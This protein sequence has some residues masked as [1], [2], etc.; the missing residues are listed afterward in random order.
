MQ[1]CKKYLPT[2]CLFGVISTS[3]LSLSFCLTHADVS[4]VEH[5][6]KGGHFIDTHGWNL[7]DPGDFVHNRDRGETQLSLT[8]IQ[9]WHNSC[10]F[11]LR[12][13]LFEDL[14]DAFLVFWRELERNAGVVLGRVTMLKKKLTVC[15]VDD[16]W[17]GVC[18]L[19]TNSA[20]D[21]TAEE[22]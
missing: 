12:R 7:K 18:K 22:A 19:T 8:E 6:V 17:M 4:P 1:S 20:S 14:L 21:R 10:L 11:V 9:K 15:C 2:G 5:G 16:G 3:T 13:I